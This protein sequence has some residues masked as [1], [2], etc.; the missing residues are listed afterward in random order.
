MLCVILCGKLLT[1]YQ[2]YFI[3]FLATQ[4][5]DIFLSPL[6]LYVPQDWLLTSGMW[7]EVMYASFNP[8]PYSLHTYCAPFFF[9]WLNKQ[10]AEDLRG[11]KMKRTTAAWRIT[12]WPRAPTLNCGRIIIMSYAGPIY[13]QVLTICKWIN[14][15]L[16]ISREL[17]SLWSVALTSELSCQRGSFKFTPGFSQ[18]SKILLMGKLFILLCLTQNRGSDICAENYPLLKRSGDTRVVFL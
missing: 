12:Y 7:V 10:D 1:D 16:P 6:C 3:F 18:H 11:H 5:S 15:S 2:H 8:D 4:L 9:W 14:C 17:K 13:R